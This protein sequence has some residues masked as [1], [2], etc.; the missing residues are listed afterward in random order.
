MYIF[1]FVL[2]CF[3]TIILGAGLLIEVLDEKV[4]PIPTK[5]S[6]PVFIILLSIILTKIVIWADSFPEL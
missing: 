4:L 3:I 2:C 5:I 6:L 1:M